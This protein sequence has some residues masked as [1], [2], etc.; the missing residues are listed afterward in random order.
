MCGI[1]KQ[2][3]E[4]EKKIQD[5]LRIKF[6]DFCIDEKIMNYIE[7]PPEKLQAMEEVRSDRFNI[8]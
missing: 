7:P 2:A 3:I 5:E 6:M 8:K 4:E 1:I